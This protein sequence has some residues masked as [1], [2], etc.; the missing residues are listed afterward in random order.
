[1]FYSSCSLILEGLWLM[2]LACFS[3]EFH[4][5]KC[6]HQIFLI[7]SKDYIMKLPQQTKLLSHPADRGCT[8]VTELI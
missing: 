5:K 1:M 8:D 7:Y 3:F 4:L 6:G 2:D